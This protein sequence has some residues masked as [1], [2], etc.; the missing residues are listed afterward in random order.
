M[1]LRKKLLVK[2]LD[3]QTTK[4]LYFILYLLTYL[5]N[6]KKGFSMKKIVLLLLMF[7]F[8]VYA[9][10]NVFIGARYGVVKTHSGAEGSLSENTLETVSKYFVMGKYFD[11]Y[12]VSLSMDYE[13]VIGF[14][15]AYLF[16]LEQSNFTPYLGGGLYYN[17]YTRTYQQDQEAY[18]PNEEG[19][20]F[21]VKGGFTYPIN[22]QFEIEPSIIIGLYAPTRGD[23]TAY[24]DIG[25]S[26]NYLFQTY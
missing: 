19:I 9:K 7:A 16:N 8:S 12:R 11:S 4:H 17:K 22:K 25:V 24:R 26:I 2:D 6:Q 5:L 15:A 1:S 10:E 14:D 18:A 21:R 20:V 13:H 23:A 3:L